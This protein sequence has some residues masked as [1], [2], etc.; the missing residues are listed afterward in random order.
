VRFKVSKSTLV[1][2]SL[3]PGPWFVPIT[4]FLLG[5]AVG[6]VLAWLT[7]P[8]PRTRESRL[9]FH[10]LTRREGRDLESFLARMER[11]AARLGDPP[12]EAMNRWI[13][14]PR[15]FLPMLRE[16]R[17]LLSR[18]L[19]QNLE[20]SGL[21]NVEGRGGANASL[22]FPSSDSPR[23]ELDRTDSTPSPSST[24][25]SGQ[26][27]RPPTSGKSGLPWARASS[28]S[29]RGSPRPLD[30]PRLEDRTV[31]DMPTPILTPS[32][33]AREA[34]GAVGTR[35]ID[36]AASSNADRLASSS[37][38]SRRFRILVIDN[39]PEHLAI[40]KYYL[41]RRGF[42]VQTAVNGLE[43]QDRVQKTEFDLVLLD[44]LMSPLDGAATLKRLRDLGQR[45]PAL[46]MTTRCDPHEEAHAQSQGFDG[47]L[48]KPIDIDRFEKLLKQFGLTGTIRQSPIP[49]RSPD[50]GLDS[51]TT[52]EPRQG[53][54]GERARRR[55][56][57]LLCERAQSLAEAIAADR[58]DV[59]EH[60]AHLTR[61][62]A[63]L[64]GMDH[65]GE[66][67]ARAET[68]LKSQGG[69]N[70]SQIRGAIEEFRLQLERTIQ[71][72]RH[73]VEIG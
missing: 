14:D 30:A 38:R 36:E 60:I 42:H 34:Q 7:R 16:A 23:S 70:S 21:T 46:A 50:L 32:S 39:D 10:G 11:E 22:R 2:D 67:A 25:S 48:V 61:G 35:W 40:L 13:Q 64:Y 49:P 33:S 19:D 31:L 65:L 18:R 27:A 53:G 15:G 12:L 66:A 54:D 68:A 56:T 63:A 71:S 43:A 24:K 47:L 57:E 69:W 58:L 72:L 9:S 52:P 4:L 41:E 20:D 5:V 44:L 6:W 45:M 8:R 73:Q 1:S 26:N 55:Y 3:Q 29:T 37:P 28:T 51:A 62:S 59:I 17:A